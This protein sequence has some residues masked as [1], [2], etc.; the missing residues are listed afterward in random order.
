MAVVDI[1]IES[2]EWDSRP[3]LAV[4]IEKAIH[5]AVD[6]S[7][8]TTLA[9]GEIAVLLTDDEG[10]AA[11]NE[12]WRGKAVPTNVLSWPATS[13]KLLALSPMIGDI[14]VA[15][16]TASREAGEEGKTFADHVL[17]LCVHGTLHLLG[18]D[19]ET[20]EQA[21]TMERLEQSI[22]HGLG[23]ADP[24]G[25]AARKEGLA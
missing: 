25:M 18:F 4:Q 9:T 3:E 22:L 15:H 5:A 20:D 12:R 6:A 13:P 14:A 21:E 19:H 10:I 2:E 11:L 7:G 16:E 24:Y 23:I 1:V 17:H 8:V